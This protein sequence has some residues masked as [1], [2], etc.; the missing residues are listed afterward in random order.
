M[1]EHYQLAPRVVMEG[2]S[3]GGLFVY[4]WAVQNLDR[5][6]CIYCDTPVCD[7]RSWPAK[8]SGLGSDAAW[9][10]CSKEYGL[11]DEQSAMFK[12]TRSIM[13]PGI[14]AAKVPILHIVSENDHVVPPSEN[15]YRL[16]EAHKTSAMTCK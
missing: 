16:R 7:I 2:V 13:R 4:N 14:A 8:G 9:N 10:Q 15:T 12:G 6:A 3:R 1:I 11:T 5:V